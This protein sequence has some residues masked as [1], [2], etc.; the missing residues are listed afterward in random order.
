MKYFFFLLFFGILLPC[1]GQTPANDPHW[2]LK[3]EDDFD[4]L[5]VNKWRKVHNCD[6]MGGFEMLIISQNVDVLNSQLVLTVNNLPVFCPPDAT[7]VSWICDNEPCDCGWYAH[8]A[9]GVETMEPLEEHGY[10]EALVKVPDDVG[11]H[12]AFWAFYGYPPPY[13]H[14]EEIDMFEMMPGKQQKC[15]YDPNISL[16]THNKNHM[17]SNLWHDAVQDPAVSMISDYTDWHIYGMEWSP[18]RIV[19]Y[20]D[21]VPFRLIHNVSTNHPTSIIFGMGLNQEVETR[22]IT[23]PAKM[24]VEWVKVWELKKECAEFISSGH[25]DFLD[26]NDELKNFIIIGGE[27]FT[28]ALSP[29]QDITLRASQFIE[30]NGDF[31][32][33]MGASLYADANKECSED[34]NTEC[35]QTYNPCMFFNYD[36]SIK[37]QI[38]L[39]GI[40]CS[41]NILPSLFDI[42]MQ[43]TDYTILK[44]GVTIT[45]VPGKFIE[46]KIV[47]CK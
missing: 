29:E 15:P 24:Y 26:Y 16:Y 8:S 1:F 17:T 12:S 44:K 23:F 45:P 31:N 37:K 25:Y 47:N 42:S 3:W 11:L 38:E 41:L 33:P 2:Q 21:S 34:L 9:G 39:G 35:S 10:F 40:G 4:T 20:L 13:P 46:L 7:V 27:G 6:K 5:N 18:S 32:V 43:S 28:N 30:L 22:D 36:N 14:S 19:L